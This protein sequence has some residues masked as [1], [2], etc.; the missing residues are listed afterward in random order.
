VIILAYSPVDEFGNR[1]QQT[2]AFSRLYLSPIYAQ[3]A[4]LL[5]EVKFFVALS[6]PH[7]VVTVTTVAPLGTVAVR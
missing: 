4:V 1:K 6:A 3:R 7:G 2:G 5:N